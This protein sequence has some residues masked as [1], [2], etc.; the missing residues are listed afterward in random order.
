LTNKLTTLT[1]LVILLCASLTPALIKN[2]GATQSYTVIIQ[3]DGTI[4][5]TPPGAPISTSDNANYQLTSNLFGSITIQRNNSVLDGSSFT[6]TGSGSGT[7]VHLLQVTGVTVTNLIVTNFEWDIA[8]NSTTNSIITSN[9][10]L[11]TQYGI[12]FFNSTSTL[13]SANTIDNNTITGPYNGGVGVVLGYYSHN[14]IVSNNIISQCIWGM[15]VYGLNNEITSN[16]LLSCIGMGIDVV[17]HYATNNTI[18][19]N[20][21][22]NSQ[23]GIEVDQWASFNTVTNNTIKDATR[24]VYIY[25]NNV[26]GRDAFNNTVSY[27]SITNCSIAGIDVYACSNAT[28]KGN[29]I[30]SAPTGITISRYGD[31]PV[32]GSLILDNVI[33][34]NNY[35]LSLTV[36]NCTLAGN[37]I[38]STYG[39]F[40]IGSSNNT[41]TNNLAISNNGNSLHLYECSNNLIYHN[42]FVSKYSQNNYPDYQLTDVGSN[43]FDNGVTGNFWSTQD[44][45]SDGTYTLATENLDHHTLANPLYA[46]RLNITSV[47]C[48][49]TNITG[50]VY[51]LENQQVGISRVIVKDATFFNWILDN[52]NITGTTITVTMDSHHNLTAAFDIPYWNVTISETTNGIIQDDQSNRVDGTTIAHIVDNSELVLN[53]I[54]NEGYTFSNWYLSNSSRNWYL[55]DSPITLSVGSTITVEAYFEAAYSL[56]IE[57]S[58]N[59]AVYNGDDDP[60]DGTT[61]TVIDGYYYDLYATPDNGFF[62]AYWLVDGEQYSTESSISIQISEPHTVKAVFTLAPV[63]ILPS[64]SP[65]WPMYMHDPAHTSLTDSESPTTN[66]LLWITQLG[67]NIYSQPSV[68]NG[69]IYVGTTAGKVYAINATTTHPLWYFETDDSIS[70]S[71]AVVNGVV[72][73]GSEDGYLYALNAADGEQIWA[74]YTDDYIYASPTVADGVVYFSTEYGYFYALNATTDNPEG[75][76]LWSYDL[77]DYIYESAAVGYGTVFVPSENGILYA[78]NATATDPEDQLLWAY[79]VNDYIYTSPAVGYGMVYIGSDD[80]YVYA[81]NATS[82]EDNIDDQLIWAYYTEDYVEGSPALAYGMVYISASESG[83]VLALNATTNNPDGELLWSF[84]AEDYLYNSLAVANGIVYGTSKYGIVFALDALTDNPEGDCVW[85]DYIESRFYSGPVISGGVLYACTSY[86]EIYAYAENTHVTFTESGL[87]QGASW[88]VTFCGVTQ[89]STSDT[90]T[91][92]VCRNGEFNY[93]ISAP[94]GYLTED[95]LSATLNLTGENLSQNVTFTSPTSTY[96]LTVNSAVGGTTDPNSGSYTYNSDDSATVTATP[97]TGYAF[98]YWLLDSQTNTTNATIEI[99]MNSNHTIKPVF[100][101]LTYEL[102]INSAPGGQTSPISGSYT[103]NHSETASITASASEGY[104]FEHWLLDGQTNTTSPT[105]SLSMTTNHTLTPV[106]TQITYELT[107]NSAVGGTTLPTNGSYTYNYAQTATITATPSEGYQFAGWLL[108]GQTDTTDNTINIEMLAN[109][110]ITPIFAEATTTITATKTTDNQTYT[111]GIASGNITA[112]QFSNMTITPY[113]SS[114]TTVVAFTLTGPTGTNGTG[115][116]AIPKEAIPFGTTPE[117]YI[118]GLRAMDQSYTQD[119]DYYYITFSTH[120]STHEI[121][122]TFA[123]ETEYSDLSSVGQYNL[124]GMPQASSPDPTVTPIPQPTTTPITSP[125]ATPTGTTNAGISSYLVLLAAAALMFIIVIGLAYRRKKSKEW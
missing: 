20:N 96:E 112:T 62:F 37:T 88:S 110:T 33:S 90:M 29:T 13:C 106:F 67:E 6:L 56:T 52:Q 124:T 103:Y 84:C 9:T 27:N 119:D 21:I 76:C 43:S 22:T 19:A 113:A 58:Q 5:S 65:D 28:V 118:D 98:A 44:G 15:I 99:T 75:E 55:Y 85:Y 24:G 26:G 10:L 39:C 45:L 17:D 105:I 121:S 93:T 73:I 94:E 11:V 31:V 111:V 61:V 115:T 38:T 97:Q 30:S 117:V 102:T 50:R 14:N 46:K 49:T 41:L 40:V 82:V 36:S 70:S 116:I 120:F 66:K 122:I 100:T 18:S 25:G 7:G 4:E 69:V 59:G 114:I 71:P 107:I 101:Q 2:V 86:G 63:Y 104:Q 95:A 89:S 32:N 79:E 81:F 92:V 54:P 51:S 108:D 125:T 83:Y 8:L 109:H 34:N 60:V 123:S 72:Y 48:G 35:G 3:P 68:V 12:A 87:A 23:T 1:L 77:D 47:G 74:Y 53:A 16:T 64:P 42:D 80:G 91:F 78:L 57:T